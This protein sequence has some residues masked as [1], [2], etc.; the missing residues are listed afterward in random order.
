MREIKF[1]NALVQ[2]QG[3]TEYCAGV[4]RGTVVQ[5]AMMTTGRTKTL[6]TENMSSV[7][8]SVLLSVRL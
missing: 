7:R 5:P 6:T 4:K 3:R 1:Q 8:P 2:L